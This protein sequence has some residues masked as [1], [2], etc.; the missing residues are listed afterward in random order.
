MGH[1]APVPEA[2][3]APYRDDLAVRWRAAL[4][5]EGDL[6]KQNIELV[7]GQLARSKEFEHRLFNG[8]Q[9][10]VNLLLLQCRSAVPAVAEQLNTAAA[11]I[12]A[13]ARVH[14]RL[15]LVDYQDK[16]EIKQH[17]QD[18]CTDLAGLLFADQVK[19]TIVV[20]SPNCEL[21]ATLA[22]P[23]SLIVNELI[24]N[25]VK[26]AKSNI[27]VRFESLTPVSHSISVVDEGPGLP[28]GFDPAKS[29]GLGMQIVLA[30][31]KEIG[32]E[33]R[34]LTGTNGRGTMVTL[35]FFLPGPGIGPGH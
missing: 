14:H 30:L 35:T 28:G 15:H 1:A 25:S 7:K 23:I 27:T 33:L 20:E 8:L 10:I 17:L 18:L 34:F 5:R 24:T 13:F 31:V 19:Q 4:E 22:V 32:G 3:F 12:S 11:R 29:A 9:L 2:E 26:H 16:V 6:R 21:P